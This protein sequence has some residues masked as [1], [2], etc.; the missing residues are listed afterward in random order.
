LPPDSAPWRA[1]PADS[2]QGQYVHP[3]PLLLPQAT[4]K[5]SNA[6]QI[7][8]KEVTA[9]LA[10]VNPD[11]F[12]DPDVREYLELFASDDIS[13]ESL[14]LIGAEQAEDLPESTLLDSD[15]QRIDGVL[16]QQVGLGWRWGDEGRGAHKGR[17]A[18]TSV[19][20]RGTCTR[21]AASGIW[22]PADIPM[23]VAAH[24]AC[25]ARLASQHLASQ[26]LYWP[27]HPLQQA[28]LCLTLLTPAA[29]R[30]RCRACQ[31]SS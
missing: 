27:T 23:N 7:T 11:V 31:Q 25:Q 10:N 21:L 1:T 8:D 3:P 16:S 26:R 30:H 24:L 28:R 22:H 19:A 9:E 18:H 20:G 17:G 6:A 13:E 15:L 14:Q 4:R 29:R 2:L 12:E 5:R